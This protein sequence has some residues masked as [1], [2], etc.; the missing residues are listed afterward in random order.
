[1]FSCAEGSEGSEL[2]SPWGGVCVEGDGV[3]AACTEQSTDG[4]GL[5]LNKALGTR[6]T[7][8]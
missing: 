8:Y 6:F 1:M 5:G 4:L 7:C 3:P 2:G